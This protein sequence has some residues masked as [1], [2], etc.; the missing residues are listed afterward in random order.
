MGLLANHTTQFLKQGVYTPRGPEPSFQGG[1]GFHKLSQKM[2]QGKPLNQW[3]VGGLPLNRGGAMQICMRNV[4]WQPFLLGGISEILAVWSWLANGYF[5]HDKCSMKA[6]A[7]REE[8]KCH[9]QR[10]CWYI[11]QGPEMCCFINASY[12]H[13]CLSSCYTGIT[14]CLSDNGSSFVVFV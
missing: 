13:S 14:K 1:V 3:G 9:F 7:W 4:A 12:S 8:N 10:S 6:W 11:N 5:R 2:G